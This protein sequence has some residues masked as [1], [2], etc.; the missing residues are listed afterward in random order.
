MKIRFKKEK[1][2]DFINILLNRN[3]FYKFY[4]FFTLIVFTFFVFVFFQTGFWENNKKK[5]FN[6]INLNGIV[7]YIHLP[8]IFFYKFNSFFESQKEIKL[9]ISQKNLI[10]IED[11]RNKIMEFTKKV[12]PFEKIAAFIQSVQEQQG[13]G[14][15]AEAVD[16]APATEAQ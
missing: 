10:K 8:E 6:R 4:F 11:N 9:D 15:S 1:K 2:L 14:E 3:F 13:D 12:V 5:F 16:Q 7:N